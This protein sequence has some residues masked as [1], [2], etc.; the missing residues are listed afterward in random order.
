LIQQGRGEGFLDTASLSNLSTM[1]GVPG[2]KSRSSVFRIHP[3]AALTYPGFVLPCG[4]PTFSVLNRQ[5]CWR[6][7]TAPSMALVERVPRRR[8]LR[9]T[10]LSTPKPGL[11]LLRR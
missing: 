10:D 2:T 4:T 5:A 8:G 1:V 6:A 7:P 9:P 11:R 3:F